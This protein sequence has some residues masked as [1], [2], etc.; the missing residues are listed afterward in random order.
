MIDTNVDTANITYQIPANDD[1]IRS[2]K[3]M[4]TLVANAI[5]EGRQGSEEKV[6][7]VATETT[8]AEEVVEN[9]SA[10]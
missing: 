2:V 8:E 1:A 7:E 6:E 3:L 5:I 9:G 4:S 10:E